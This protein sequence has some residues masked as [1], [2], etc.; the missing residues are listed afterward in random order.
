MGV[1]AVRQDTVS[2]LV[3]ALC[4][5]Y[6]RRLEGIKQN[7]FSHRVTVE[8]KFINYKMLE[9]AREIV[10]CEAE[11]YIREIGRGIGYAKSLSEEV[12][13]A[14]YKQKKAEVK[15]NIAKKLYFID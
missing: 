12:S 13:E 15:V 11:L 2:E 3:T 7:R 4:R 14:F 1:R 5:D 8:L 6:D 10:G 9:A